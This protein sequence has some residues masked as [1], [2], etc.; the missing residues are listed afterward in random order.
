MAE[1]LAASSARGAAWFNLPNAVTS[2]TNKLDRCGCN[3][4]H[5]NSY[6]LNALTCDLFFPSEPSGAKGF[7]NSIN[8]SIVESCRG[9]PDHYLNSC[10]VAFINEGLCDAT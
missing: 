5:R 10:H 6:T 4:L 8:D 2:L 9:C 7:P 1:N 3:V